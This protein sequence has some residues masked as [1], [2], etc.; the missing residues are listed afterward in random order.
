MQLCMA[1]RQ[2]GRQA[3]LNNANLKASK[4]ATVKKEVYFFKENFILY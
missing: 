3:V 4:P 1:G 2:A